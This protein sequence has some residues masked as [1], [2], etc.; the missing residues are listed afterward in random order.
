MSKFASID[1]VLSRAAN[2]FSGDENTVGGL[3]NPSDESLNEGPRAIDVTT[4]EGFLVAFW[5]FVAPS[6]PVTYT[7]N[8][9]VS[10]LPTHHQLC[11]ILD[12]FDT[13]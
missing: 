12:C 3:T 1:E 6:T 8:Q 5:K 4:P 7:L 13:T 11:P 2:S 9:V 10:I